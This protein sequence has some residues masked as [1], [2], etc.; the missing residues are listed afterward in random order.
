[1]RRRTAGAAGDAGPNW[2]EATPMTRST[3]ALAILLAVV[4]AA[5]G[6]EGS[7]S[8]GAATPA[9]GRS[10]DPTP[11]VATPSAPPSSSSAP[12]AEPIVSPT[13]M[14]AAGEPTWK[15]VPDQPA[16]AAASMT[17]V[18]AGPGGYVAVGCRSL[19]APTSTGCITAAWHSADGRTWEQVALPSAGMIDGGMDVVGDD[20]GYLAWGGLVEPEGRAGVWSS[21]DGITWRAAPAIPAFNGAAI[22]SVVR[23]ADAWYASGGA[24]ERGAVLF[25]SPDGVTWQEIEFRDETGA[26]Y[27]PG[28][29]IWSLEPLVAT[30]DGLLGFGPSGDDEVTMSATFRSTDGQRWQAT[31]ELPAGGNVGDVVVL[32]GRVVATG[33]LDTE[34]DSRFAGWVSS[35]GSSW[36]PAAFPAGG[37]GGLLASGAG[38]VIMI[39][40]EG[41]SLAALWSAD[42]LTWT[43]ASS[44]PD[45]ARDG[46]ASGGACT[47]GG[48][49]P[50]VPRTVVQGLAGT[51]AGFV[52]VGET[53]LEDGGERAVVWIGSV[54]RD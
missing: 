25:T 26:A 43:P 8:P 10:G 12:T 15:R 23:F 6:A 54:P 28:D 35:G 41:E 30:G 27:V 32:N 14:P 44:V 45:A 39:G 24:G 50:D 13:P 2:W 49:C 5:C 38:E 3:P 1:M 16:F 42:G 46:S 7:T 21:G 20:A 19:V 11:G 33:R 4:L 52:A 53:D 34:A 29:P 18:A 51:D 48:A 36:T 17:G 31:N 22:H 40:G 47:G 37:R 9:P